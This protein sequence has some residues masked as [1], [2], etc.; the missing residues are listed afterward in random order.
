MTIAAGVVW[1]TICAPHMQ[2]QPRAVVHGASGGTITECA[3]TPVKSLTCTMIGRPRKLETAKEH[4][5]STGKCPSQPVVRSVGFHGRFGGSF[6]SRNPRK[7]TK[8]AKGFGAFRALSCYSCFR[9]P[10]TNPN[11]CAPSSA[12]PSARRSISSKRCCTGRFGG[13]CE[14]RSSRKDTKD[15]KGFRAFRALSRY[16]CFRPASTTVRCPQ[17]RVEI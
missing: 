11:A 1:R 6:E 4:G 10:S 13:S 17:N 12:K 3:L 14:S 15:A 9:L 8:D 2:P 16:S 7:N 5:F